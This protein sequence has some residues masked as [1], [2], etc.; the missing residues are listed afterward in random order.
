[1]N[2]LLDQIALRLTHLLM[3]Q[4]ARAL[5]LPASQALDPVNLTSYL[6]HKAVAIAA[7]I[8]WQAKA[9]WWSTRGSGP[10]IPAGHRS[11]RT[12]P[13]PRTRR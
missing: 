13:W 6:S 12:P 8:G 3:D 4:G 10:R 9:C 2:I 7:G 11:H 1:V 5:P